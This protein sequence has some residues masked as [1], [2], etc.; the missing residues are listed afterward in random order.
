[1]GSQGIISM[2]I[3]CIK[4][5][6]DLEHLVYNLIRAITIDNHLADFILK[7]EAFIDN[8]K[9]FN[10]FIHSSLSYFLNDPVMRHQI[11]NSK[12]ERKWIERAVGDLRQKSRPFEM[13]NQALILDSFYG[14]CILVDY[15]MLKG[16]E[17]SGTETFSE[18]DIIESLAG[19]ILKMKG[20]SKL[21]DTFRFYIY[22]NQMKIIVLTQLFRIFSKSTEKPFET[23]ADM[24]TTEKE[25]EEEK[26]RLKAYRTHSKELSSVL[27]NI[28]VDFIYENLE[29]SEIREFLLENL[30]P[31]IK[32]KLVSFEPYFLDYLK[33]MIEFISLN[34]TL[35]LF[36]MNFMLIIISSSVFDVKKSLSILDCMIKLFYLSIPQAR[37]LLMCINTILQKIPKHESVG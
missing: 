33:K 6:I 13:G 17:F 36:D 28:F 16:L 27:L 19:Y 21:K 30:G 20:T 2:L 23:P 11:E 4:R 29:N 5:H 18:N 14:I 9:Q 10:F 7:I 25:K 22:N 37:F 3:F 26:E 15:W 1:M 12:L 31:F 35:N 24:L 32:K 8:S 34:N